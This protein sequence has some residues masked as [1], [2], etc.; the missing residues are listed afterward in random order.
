MKKRKKIIKKIDFK[1]FFKDLN[2]VSIRVPL[3]AVILFSL[4]LVIS[5][6]LT[7][8]AWTKFQNRDTSATL[9][10]QNIF[11]AENI[12]KPQL[13]FY[14][15]SFCPYGNQIEDV[16]KP[17]YDLLGDKVEMRPR[18]IFDKIE[19]DLSS[20]C[21]TTT[22]DP[23]NC[24]TFVANSNGQLKDI[25]D[26]KNQIANMVKSCN[27]EKKYLK[28]GDNYY[29]SLHGR[30]EANQN[31]REICAY[32]LTDDKKTW[33]NFIANVNSSCNSSNADTCWEEQANKAGLDAAKIA[34][35][36]N[37]QAASLIEEEIAFT[38]KN[39]VSGSPTVYIGD[40]LF[41]PTVSATSTDKN[42]KIGKEVFELNQARTPNMLKAALC[43]AFSKAPKECL[44]KIENK[45]E[46]QAPATGGC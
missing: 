42:I 39:K 7:G 14:V 20:Y 43:T 17:V 8:V 36:F 10:S 33:W 22:P 11:D 45:V 3:V 46:E 5:T 38:T 19:G 21:K 9:S 15:M 32:N 23:A 13:D 35:C 2:K 40:Q 30:V 18:Y 6:F 27:D 41:P 1:K 4:L 29:S 28:V 31:V 44:T 26:C 24:A 34:D 12:K 25:N 37:T 16:L